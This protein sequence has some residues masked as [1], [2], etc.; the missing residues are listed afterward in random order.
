MFN[1]LTRRE[2]MLINSG[3]SGMISDACSTKSLLMVVSVPVPGFRAVDAAVPAAF[4]SSAAAFPASKSMILEVDTVCG[5]GRLG[6]KK[7][8]A[9]LQGCRDRALGPC[10]YHISN[11]LQSICR[12]SRRFRNRQSHPLGE[13]LSPIPLAPSPVLPK[14]CQ[15]NSSSGLGSDPPVARPAAPLSARKTNGHALAQR[16]L[17]RAALTFSRPASSKS[18]QTDDDALE[19]S[20]VLWTPG[21]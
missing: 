20:R 11:D 3:G 14:C 17:P 5:S 19:P 16:S 9:P 2:I 13:S 18:A 12:N 10:A 1:C 7:C 4:A 8:A 6:R 15:P 21:L